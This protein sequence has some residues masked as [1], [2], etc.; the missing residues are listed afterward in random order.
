MFRRSVYTPIIGRQ[1]KAQT[2]FQNRWM[3]EIMYLSIIGDYTD[4]PNIA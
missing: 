4:R 3:Y 1:G 2:Q